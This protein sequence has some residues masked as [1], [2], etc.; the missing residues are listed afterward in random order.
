[1]ASAEQE[2]TQVLSAFYEALDDLL[3]C[4]GLEKM[5]AAWHHVPEATTAH[6]F[7][8]WARGW[9]EVWTNWQEAFAVFGS[10]RGHA[11]RN[12]SIGGIRDLKVMVCGDVAIATSIYESKLF[13]SDGEFDMSVNCTNIARRI[14]GVWKIIHHH[15]DQAKPDWQAR[16]GRMVEQ[17]HS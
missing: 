13:M 9:D 14:D 4:K 17:G 10:Y 2:V 11:G 8:G 3:Q 7:G 6:P 5:S 12:D 15:A 16:I 1:M